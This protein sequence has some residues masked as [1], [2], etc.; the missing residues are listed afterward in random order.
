M[1]VFLAGNTAQPQ[2]CDFKM[3]GSYFDRNCAFYLG[4]SDTMIAQISRKY[5]AST[6]L[7]G[8]DTFNVTVL[9]GVDH[10]FVAALVVVLDEVHSRDRNY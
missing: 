8:K 3:K 10:V 4:D 2:A 9:P 5:T 1:D 7:L 6:V